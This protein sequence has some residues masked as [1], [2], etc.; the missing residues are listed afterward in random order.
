MLRAAA[1]GPP[2]WNNPKT[3]KWVHSGSARVCG[4]WSLAGWIYVGMKS[5]SIL[6]MNILYR[7]CARLWLYGWII[8]W[9]VARFG[10]F[11]K[12]LNPDV[13][14]YK[15]INT[16]AI[17]RA[18]DGLLKVN[19]SEAKEKLRPAILGTGTFTHTQIRGPISSRNQSA[20]SNYIEESWQYFNFIDIGWRGSRWICWVIDL[21]I[22]QV[23]HTMEHLERGSVSTLHLIMWLI[24]VWS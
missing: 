3:Y 11:I 18:C 12:V 24:F 20:N 6:Y 19:W 1:L 10:S 23:R 22:H 4:W 7:E 13:M 17:R 5:N 15:L 2:V 21:F 14:I 8:D 16:F 9:A